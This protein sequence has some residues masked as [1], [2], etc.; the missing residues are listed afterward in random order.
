[1]A[2]EAA[3]SGCLTRTQLRRLH[4][5]HTLSCL[6]AFLTFRRAQPETTSQACIY[7]VDLERFRSSMYNPAYGVQYGNA[8]TPLVKCPA[9]SLTIVAHPRN[10]SS[11]VAACHAKA[12][13]LQAH[14]TEQP[15]T[16]SEDF[17]LLSSNIYEAPSEVDLELSRPLLGLSHVEPS[18]QAH[19]DDYYMDL[20]LADLV[21]GNFSS[22]DE[23]SSETDSDAI[24]DKQTGAQVVVNR[25]DESLQLHI[26]EPIILA[27]S[28]VESSSIT[29]CPTFWC[30]LLT[31]L[32]LSH[33][34]A[35][36]WTSYRAS[37]MLGLSTV[38][39]KSVSDIP[40]LVDIG[41]ARK[42]T[43]GSF[44]EAESYQSAQEVVGQ[45]VAVNLQEVAHH[46][47]RRSSPSFLS[48]SPLPA[49]VNLV[50]S[51]TA[52]PATIASDP[53]QRCNQQ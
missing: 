50:P 35:A 28:P 4:R 48:S 22:D 3:H 51:C 34:A 19:D 46:S 52:V 32:E 9:C 23:A 40:T 6:K 7:A 10:F 49:S 21:A 24:I 45:H 30:H 5:K 25:V 37:H 20:P 11:E 17:T 41:K 43:M 33:S 27:S 47:E 26:S 15:N 36:S 53:E 18:S 1:M 14:V 12:T 29:L 13:S 42:N 44:S 8:G 31:P 38:Y 16:N 2:S 39:G